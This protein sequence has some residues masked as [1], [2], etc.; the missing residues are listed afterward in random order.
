MYPKAWRLVKAAAEDVP[1]RSYR[2]SNPG[3]LIETSL[4]RLRPHCSPKSGGKR[5]R[6][7]LELAENGGELAHQRKAFELKKK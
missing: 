1:S 7:H 4:H 2:E 5:F 6:N 3:R